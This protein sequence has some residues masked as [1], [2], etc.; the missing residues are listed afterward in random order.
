[1]L[2]HPVSRH[3][4]DGTQSNS[5]WDTQSHQPSSQRVKA[6]VRSGTE[7]L[8]CWNPAVPPQNKGLLSLT[9]TSI[10]QEV[11]SHSFTRGSQDVRS[12]CSLRSA[13]SVLA[14][15][16]KKEVTFFRTLGTTE[17]NRPAE[18]GRVN[19]LSQSWEAEAV[20]GRM[21]SRL[22]IERPCLTK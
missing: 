14:E 18:H 8:S 19:L 5:M 4:L 15:I 2:P 9:A 11:G 3:Y 10:S 6:M 16:K 1:M 12:R 21:G 17:S 13:S 22:Y 7:K 20:T